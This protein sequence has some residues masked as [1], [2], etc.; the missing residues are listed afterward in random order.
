MNTQKGKDKT[1]RKKELGLLNLISDKLPLKTF[2]LTRKVSAVTAADSEVA[3][4]QTAHS[5][6]VR[7]ESFLWSAVIPPC[8]IETQ[9]KILTGYK[10]KA[11]IVS[12]YALKMDD[13]S[14]FMGKWLFVVMKLQNL[15]T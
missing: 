12:I 11:G 1:K 14:T 8:F 5:Q 9:Q 4:L 10:L 13:S 6:V 7:A 3:V 2:S 15:Q